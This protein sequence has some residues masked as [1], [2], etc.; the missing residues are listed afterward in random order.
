LAP[1]LVSTLWVAFRDAP[2][3]LRV[4]SNQQAERLAQAAPVAVGDLVADKYRIERLLALG[5]MGVVALARH[6]VLGQQV[7]IKFLLASE[8]G[9]EAAKRFLREARAAARIHSENVVRVH[10]CGKLPGG[11][12]YMVMEHLEGIELSKEM[13]RRGAFPPEEAVDVI[14]DALVGIAEA[15]AL[16]VVHR[17]IK[18]S[19]LFLADRAGN[20]RVVKVLDF[21]ISKVQPS[22][23]SPVDEEDL[24]QTA[25]VLGSPRYI[26]P[27]QARSAK[28]VD[29]RA[30]IWS[31]GV[32]LYQLLGGEVPFGGDTFGEILTNILLHDPAPLPSL[33]DD[34]PEGLA[35]VVGV[36]LRR[37]REER[38]ANVADLADALAPFGGPRA[39]ERARRVA[40]IMG[41][42]PPAAVAVRDPRTD[43]DDA[44][45]SQ[46]RVEPTVAT[47][48]TWAQNEDGEGKRRTGL[49]V[50]AAA[51]AVAVALAVWLFQR[52][53]VVP[54]QAP[55]AVA[56]PPAPAPSPSPSPSPRAAPAPA[57]SPVAVPP[58]SAS[59]RPSSSPVAPRPVAHS[60]NPAPAPAPDPSPAPSR[61]PSDPLGRSD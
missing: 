12:P 58:A 20:E 54:P 27:E 8:R 6:E 3:P 56:S 51:I 25:M 43:V 29:A 14:L 40:A 52:E 17:D 23:E 32:V 41:A 35:A 61:K 4:H 34:L 24:T 26:S 59:A 33:R 30:D 31:V 9:E 28:D 47:V 36:C 39:A 37:E 16:G 60:P 10:D 22:P 13:K 49:F 18:P 57:P 7:A 53:P 55:A 50:G 2:R 44:P 38:Y 21:G 1:P 45:T 19:N 42:A 11:P 5:G 48:A 15:H 46:T